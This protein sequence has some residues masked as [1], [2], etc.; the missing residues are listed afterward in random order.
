MASILL[1]A[2][3]NGTMLA[4]E[5]SYSGSK[6]HAEI[7]GLTPDSILIPTWQAVSTENGLILSERAENHGIESIFQV[8]CT[9]I[10]VRLIA[11]G[12]PDDQGGIYEIR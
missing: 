12:S 5:W 11:V 3:C 9:P 7:F 6:V 1:F 8:G 4:N 2:H 10:S